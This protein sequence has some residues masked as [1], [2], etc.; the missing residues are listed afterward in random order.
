MTLTKTLGS[1]LADLAAA[2]NRGAVITLS[3]YFNSAGKII[4]S[5]TKGAVYA[6]R[7]AIQAYW[8]SLLASGLKHLVATID[9]ATITGDG[10]A[11]ATGSIAHS[12]G[13]GN[14]VVVVSRPSPSAPFKIDVLA[15]TA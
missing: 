4:P 8:K 12:A 1:R 11:Y 15:I 7:H 3:T 10:N 13:G 2:Y 14:I 6:G 5:G 9:S